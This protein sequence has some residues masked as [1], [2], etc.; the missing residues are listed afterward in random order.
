MVQLLP[1]RNQPQPVIQ[2]SGLPI[3][4]LSA[5]NERHRMLSQIVDRSASHVPE[6]GI[7]E[8]PS[9]ERLPLVE[10]TGLELLGFSDSLEDT[11]FSY[12]SYAHDS[13]E[14]AQE[15]MVRPVR[16]R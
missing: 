16:Y 3:I 12:D 11:E 15:R 7:A 1:K 14:L 13:F 5:S 9:Q 6:G 10:I 4:S 2:H 8:N